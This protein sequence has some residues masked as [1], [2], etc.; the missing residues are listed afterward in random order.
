M[1]DHLAAV[2]TTIQPPTRAMER[3][4]AALRGLDAP[5][6]VMGDAKGPAAYDLEG[7]EFASIEAQRELP[8]ALATD[9]PENHYVRK[10]LGY[11]TAM[12]RGARCIYE[13]DD[14]NAPNEH[15]AQR[16]L[17]TSAR[18]VR[19]RGWVNVYH[20]F[21]DGSIWPR[22]FPLARIAEGVDLNDASEAVSAPVQQGLAD[23]SPDVDAVWRL[24]MDRDVAFRRAESVFLG[25]GRWCPFNSQSTW[26]WPAAYPL[27]Y[28][29]STCTFRMTDIW[30]GLIAQRCLWAQGAGLVFHAPEVHQVR[31]EHDLMKD[32]EHEIPGY[33]HN[34][35][36]AQR[37]ESLSLDADPAGVG[38]NLRLCYEALVAD[39]VFDEGEMRLVDAWL[40]DVAALAGTP[41]AA[42]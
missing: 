15:F 31:N 7:A 24:T 6:F 39:G 41:R 12:Q 9:L 18:S 16:A 29:P 38:G 28:L 26:W 25:P 1:S 19:G 17:E 2:V 27:M 22:G 40:A 37:L 20:C 4:A 11:L 10:N 42:R 34:E 30:R 8:F 35:A 21:E 32:F 33:L 36:I 5:L 13:T 3:L 14:D 23:G